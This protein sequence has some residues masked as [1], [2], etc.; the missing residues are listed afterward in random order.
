M[1]TPGRYDFDIWRGD[2]KVIKVAVVHPDDEPIPLFGEW[3]SQLR[4]TA[5]SSRAI[6]CTVN[7]DDQ[8]NGV[9]VVTIDTDEIAPDDNPRTWAWDLEGSVFGTI[10]YGRPTVHMDAT[11][12]AGA[13]NGPTDEVILMLGGEKVTVVATGAVGPPGPEG[14]QGDPGPAGPQGET[15]E[16]GPAGPQGD[17][18]PAGP[19]GPQG[20]PG[21]PGEPGA[22]EHAALTDTDTDGHPAGV[23]SFTDDGLAVVTGVS[24]VQAALA[25]VDAELDDR[26]TEAENNAAFQPLDSDLTAIA[27]LTTTTHG[28]ALLT[29]ASAAASRSRLSV[30]SVQDAES[31]VGQLRAV[32]LVNRWASAQTASRTAMGA[33]LSGSG[34]W[35][36]GVVGPDGKIYG[37][38]YNAA[39]ILVIDPV[40]GTASRTAMGATLSG[41]G[42]WVGGCSARTARS[43][44]SRATPPTFW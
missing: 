30:Q 9:L 2:R 22:T 42:K 24:D 28:R 18:G 10:L 6:D 39:D 27:A 32:T 34:K 40:A 41:S 23:V 21:E 29:D 13:P 20:E 16:Q 8:E 43:T 35:W 14:P 12:V 17:P 31:F 4:P 36:G 19:E 3:R 7:A 11:R 33:T 25:K 5:G 26:P 44:A 38:P 37:I 1:T 15:G